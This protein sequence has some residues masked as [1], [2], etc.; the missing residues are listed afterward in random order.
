M[1]VSDILRFA[2]DCQ[3]REDYAH[4][5]NADIHQETTGPRETS[6]DIHVPELM[7]VLAPWRD[8]T[9][10]IAAKG[11][12]PHLTLLYPW[13]TP[14]LTA[15]DLAALHGAIADYEPF[16]I[17]FTSLGRFSPTVLFLQLADDTAILALMRA[18]HTVFPDTPPYGGAFP[19]PTPHL[20]VAKATS[21]AEL[22]QLEQEVTIT[23]APNLPLVVQVQQIVVME[24][25][26]NGD[27]HNIAII[28][29]AH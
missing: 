4:H 8:V 6:I 29:L 21:D 27:W 20:T 7:A 24:D 14:P 11:V 22:D 26:H 1:Y 19:L 10:S 9:I 13:R 12:P 15:Q 5:M 17:T 3:Q 28:P 23:L 16:P 18:I 2:A 25:D